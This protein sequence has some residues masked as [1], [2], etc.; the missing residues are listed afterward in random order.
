MARE[1]LESESTFIFKEA[2]CVT[3]DNINEHTGNTTNV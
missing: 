1:L 2:Q 3:K